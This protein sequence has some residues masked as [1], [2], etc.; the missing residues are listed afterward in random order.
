MDLDGKH[1]RASTQPSLLAR[2]FQHE[3]DHLHGKLFIDYL[4]FL[5]RR[6]ALAEWEDMKDKYP[7]QRRVL[8]PGTSTPEQRE[9]TATRAGDVRVLFWGTP[10]FATPALRALL[11]EGFDV[12]GVVTQPDKPQGRSRSTLVPSPV[13]VVALDE[14]IPVLQPER[15]RGDDFVAA[16]RDARAR[17]L[18]RRRLRPHPAAGGDRPAADGHAEHSRVAAAALAR[19]RADPG[20]HPRRR[21]GD[22]RL[23]HADG[24]GARRRTGDPAGAHRRSWMTRP[25]ASSRCASPSSAPWPSSKR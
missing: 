4:S 1:V 8:T 19:R 24:A 5:K 6:R 12:V 16:V 25:A 10:E 14:E 22:G 11:G 23:D 3:I 20:G 13:K 7:G 15:P 17:H 2:A 9:A 21:H 18:R